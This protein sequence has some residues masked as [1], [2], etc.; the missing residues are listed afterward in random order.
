MTDS[1]TNM[2][3]GTTAKARLHALG[4]VAR[5]PLNAAGALAVLGGV[6]LVPQAALIAWCVQ[7]GLVEGAAPASLLP[8]LGGLLA[9][10]LLRAVIGW[11]S[12]RLADRAVEQIR[13][14][15]RARLARGLVARGPVWV[16]AQQSGALAER[17]GAHVDALEGYFGGFIPLRA[18]VVGV[19]LAILLAVFFVDRTVGL[20]LLLTMPL[21]PVFMM[22]VGWGAQA[23]S[24][25]QLQALTRM[26]GHFADRLRGLG[27]IRLYG[28]G[29]A[30]LHGI[31]AAAE[32]LRV[33]S[34]RVLRIAFLSS[35]VLEFFASLSVAMIALYLGLTYLGMLDLR[36][37]P[38]TLGAGVFCLLLAPDFYAPLRKL[39]TH[40]HDRAA[41]LAAMDEI[42]IVLDGDTPNVSDTPVTE[43]STATTP[44]L[45]STHGLALRHAGGARDVLHDVTL[46]LQRDQHVALTGASGD[47]KSTLLEA[48]AGWLPAQAGTLQRAPGLRIG[49]APQRPFLFAGSLRDN[50][51][52]A[53]PEASD[54][55]LEQAAEAAQV[56]RFAARLPEG[57]DTVIGERGFGLSG[58]EARRVALARVFLRD[59]DLLLLDEPT[60]FLDPDTEAD[61]L[62]AIR[63]FARGRAL[64]MATHSPMAQAALPQTWRLREGRLYVD[65][66]NP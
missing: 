21:V 39:A 29:E 23:A 59:P 14:D 32:E 56:M 7:R 36:G 27:L 16:R 20:V 13:V 45:L 49:Y 28:R 6:L 5:T 3:A 26:G 22:L 30:E 40:Y 63:Q 58:G 65:G 18:E 54:A 50:L 25:R 41:A 9:T 53:Q 55:E 61:V 44:T 15:T 51:R 66:G 17:M 1:A 10:L 48:L 35:A 33:R 42:A 64:L 8:L 2:P 11:L 19:P 37:A 4:A 12:R 47:G 38:L 52:M 43:I 62:Q 24:Q 60:A 31:R 34:L 46:D 57:L